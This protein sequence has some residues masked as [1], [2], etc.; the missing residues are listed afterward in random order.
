M[1]AEHPVA[2]DIGVDQALHAGCFQL[3]RDLQRVA[4]AGFGPARNRGLAGAGVDGDDQIVRAGGQRGGEEARVAERGGAEDDSRDADC[5]VAGDGFGVAHAAADLH[6]DAE[7]GDSLDSVG[8]HGPPLARAV[9]IDDVQ[10]L[11]ALFDP[12]ARG[13]GG[14]LI[15]D[16]LAVVIALG[17]AHAA[18]AADVDGGQDFDHCTPAAALRKLR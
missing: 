2:G 14:V 18:S 9:E 16:G 4:P 17:E 8:V 5:A 15:E 6:G 1:A 13:V 10:P 3:L 12:A 11:R 7:G